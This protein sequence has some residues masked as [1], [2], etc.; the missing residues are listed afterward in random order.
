V[1]GSLKGVGLTHAQ[2]H[3]PPICGP[4]AHKDRNYSEI[5]GRD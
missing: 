3:K 4:P 1:A 2:V 5:A